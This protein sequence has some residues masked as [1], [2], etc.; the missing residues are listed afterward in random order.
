MDPNSIDIAENRRRML[1]GE[2]Y[3]AWTP[4]LTADR[5]RCKAATR[6]FN[7]RCTSGNASRRELVELW[8]A[9]GRSLLS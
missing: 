1:A 4:D 5:Q 6:A 8:K 7:E 3:Y 9:Y 2:F